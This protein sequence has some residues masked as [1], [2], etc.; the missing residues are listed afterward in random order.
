M[1]INRKRG[2]DSLIFKRRAKLNRE[3]THKHFVVAD[4]F[5]DLLFALVLPVLDGEGSGHA[6]NVVQK[7]A[8][9]V[10][11]IC[12]Q[13]NLQSQYKCQIDLIEATSIAT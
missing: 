4:S 1:K 11:A 2:R 3:S 8:H 13:I 5:N 6:T 7:V 12:C 10:L 9:H